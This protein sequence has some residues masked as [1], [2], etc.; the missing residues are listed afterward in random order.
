MIGSVACWMSS[1]NDYGYHRRGDGEYGHERSCLPSRVRRLE[2]VNCNSYL[3]KSGA[4]IEWYITADAGS[5]SGDLQH[6]FDARH[7]AACLTPAT[8]MGLETADTGIHEVQ[9]MAQQLIITVDQP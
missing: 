7:T 2:I 5:F 3:G 8:G 9:D 6:R 1:K 4:W